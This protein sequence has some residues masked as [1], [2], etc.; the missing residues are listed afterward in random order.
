MKKIL[1]MIMCAAVIMGS[2]AGCGGQGDQGTS[3]GA[4][5]TKYK[6]YAG[7]SAE[8]ITATLTT[9]QKAAQMLMT[10][11]YDTSKEDMKANCY[12]S[13]LS[14]SGEMDYKE[15]QTMIDTFQEGAL[16]SDAGIPMIYGQDQVHGVYGCGNAVVFPHNVNLGAADDEDLSYRVGLAI[17]DE[18]KMTHMMWTF[19]PVVAQTADQRWGRSYESFGSDLDVI[20]RQSV[21]HTKGLQEGGIAACAKHFFADGNV[22]MGTGEDSDEERLIDRGDAKLTD[23]EIAALLDVYQAQ[24][25]AGVK[26]IMISH[27]SVNG[28]KMHEN[29]EYIDYLR[30]E[31]GF[32]GM[33]VGDWGSVHNITGESYYDKVVK[34]V[35]AGVDMLME[36]TTK[37]ET[38]DIIIEAVE[39]GDISQ[40]RLDDAVA[41]IIQLKL[42]MGL[43]EDPFLENIETV[44]QEP[45]SDEYRALAEEAVEKSLVLAKNEND[46]LPLKKGT[47]VYIMGPAADNEQ[48]L[49]GGWTIAWQGNPDIDVTG[50]TSILDGFEQKADELGITVITDEADADKADVVLLAVGEYPY[51]EWYGDEED[52]DLC[53]DL[54]L[55]GNKEAIEK[56]KALGKPVVCCIVAGRNVFIDKYADD[57]D[58]IVM[59]YLPG[60]EGQGIADVLCGASDFSGHL[61]CPWYTDA[62]QF[63]TDNAWLQK[64]FGLKYSE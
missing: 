38:R 18:S 56:A 14:V 60:S 7:M 12:G 44:Q 40:E 20:K 3:E 35:N 9:E 24:I 2:L 23:E 25:D 22:L 64:G 11:C 52:M 27:S 45:G 43:F 37:E 33:I 61:P 55:E 47:S 46:V 58:G 13:V 30:N 63:G 34:S 4:T 8:E 32:D 15:W 26:T 36:V 62:S 57:W 19:S 48:A 51:S 42:D 10:A 59:C 50:A 1:A 54:A 31:M 53:S 5:A 29:K 6:E 17:A 21:A 28:V 16:E 49:C 39:K 41:H